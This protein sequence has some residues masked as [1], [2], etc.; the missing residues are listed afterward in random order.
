MENTAYGNLG[1]RD[2]TLLIDAI[3]AGRVVPI[4][5]EKVFYIKDGENRIPVK[6]YLLAKLS[7]KFCPDGKMAEDLA[8]G[9]FGNLRK[10]R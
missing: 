9:K 4:L 3:R 5:G 7:G 1:E 6:E 10:K 8:V 2:W